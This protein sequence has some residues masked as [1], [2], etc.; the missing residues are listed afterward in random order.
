MM[1]VEISDVGSTQ[2]E[3]KV[4]VPR[5]EV[6][7]VT[8]DI[9]RDISQKV[10]IRGFRKG[11]APRHIIRMYYSD[12]IQNELSKKLVQDKFEQAAK[13]QDLFV[14]SMPEITNDPPKE[15]EDF[16]FTAKFDVKPEVKLQKYT[17][18]SLK[19]PR[20]EVEDGN[21]E[22]VVTRLQET[23]AT[24]KD[25]DD[26]EYVVKEKDYVIVDVTAEDHPN[27]NRSKMTVEAGARSALPGLDQAALGMKVGEEKAIT[28][29]FPEAHFLEEMRGKSAQVTMKVVS[30][31]SRELPALDDEFAKKVR[32]D[33]GSMDELK[34]AIRKDLLERLE[35]D[36]RNHLERQIRDE[37]IKA[38]PFD[39]PESMIRFQAAMMIQGMSERLS[40]QGYK[41][42]D[43]Y[44]DTAS[45][46]EET[47]ASAESMVR[48]SL[49]L[50][51]IAKEQGY[52][53]TEEELDQELQKLAERYNMSAETVRKGMEERGGLEEIRF[54]IVEKKVYN[55]IID[56]SQVEEVGRT[57]EKSDDTGADRS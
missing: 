13:E 22:D 46:K 31:K 47:L 8:D 37:L 55:Y 14:V 26:P 35:V 29:E 20:I 36:S 54:G 53:A 24:I 34:E 48:T 6:N 17:E 12:Y 52:E 19:K 11:K 18:F 3:M 27:L 39:V 51:A 33:V 21:I 40:A 50:E 43:L 49:V 23:Y 38:N 28:I 10:M 56:N 5:Q 45:L 2:K 1:K 4:V 42:E 32:P 57:E 7:K 25:V 16:T 15:D 9:Y 44:P 30:I 41:M